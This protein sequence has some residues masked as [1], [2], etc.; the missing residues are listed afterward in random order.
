VEELCVG[1]TLLN[2]C[3]A[4]TLLFSRSLNNGKRD[5]FL[6][7]SC[8]KVSFIFIEH[9]RFLRRV[10][11]QD[12]KQSG[13]HKHLAVGEKTLAQLHERIRGTMQLMEQ[14]MTRLNM[15][16]LLTHSLVNHIHKPGDP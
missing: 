12:Y 1:I 2:I 14:H 7:E 10:K 13:V 16:T 3:N 9:P 8:S 11:V 6:F 5:N 4:G 15:R